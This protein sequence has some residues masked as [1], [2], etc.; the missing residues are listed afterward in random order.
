ML[1]FKANISYT[2]LEILFSR[3]LLILIRYRLCII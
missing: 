1:A 2:R 3:M